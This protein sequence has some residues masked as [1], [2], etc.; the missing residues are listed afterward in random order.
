MRTLLHP[1]TQRHS[2]FGLFV[3]LCCLFL[4]QASSTKHQ[5]NCKQKAPMKDQLTMGC[6]ITFCFLEAIFVEI[7]FFCFVFVCWV[8]SAGCL[9]N[10]VAHCR[11]FP[12]YSSNQTLI[13]PLSLSASAFFFLSRF[14]SSLICSCWSSL[15]SDKL[16]LIEA[17]QSL[18]QPSALNTPSAFNRF[19]SMAQPEQLVVG[20]RYRLIKKIGSGAFGDIYLGESLNSGQ[21]VAVKLESVKAKFPQLAYEYKLYK[22]LAGGGEWLNE[23]MD[24]WMNEWMIDWLIDWNELSSIRHSMNSL[25]I[26]FS[27]R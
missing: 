17:L 10:I 13:Y 15:H 14:S 18:V 2:L 12:P 4:M 27:L 5:T 23:W 11:W 8:L 9:L 16:P 20:G 25:L 26:H 6:V 3:C 19:Y 22:I 7:F 21:E 1:H 24:D